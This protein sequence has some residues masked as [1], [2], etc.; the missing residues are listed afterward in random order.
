MPEDGW[1]S[2]TVGEHVGARIKALAKSKGR[3]S[4]TT[5]RGSWLR[6]ELKASEEDWMECRICGARLKAKNMPEH[7]LRCI[8]EDID[9]QSHYSLSCHVPLPLESLKYCMP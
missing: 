5:W 4:A 2:L 6:R 9:S 7:I 8:Q 3:P 1:T